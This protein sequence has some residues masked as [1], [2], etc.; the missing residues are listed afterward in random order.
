MLCEINIL[1]M[2]SEDRLYLLLWLET[3]PYSVRL[4]E[5]LDH[6]SS[7][8]IQSL[9]TISEALHKAGMVI[10]LHIDN[11][12]R[13]VSCI[14]RKYCSNNHLDGEQ[15]VCRRLCAKCIRTLYHWCNPPETCPT[16][17]VCRVDSFREGFRVSFLL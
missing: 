5:S 4:Q 7:C 2:L 8:P 3:S 11:L 1:L 15:V 13:I 6:E 17:T 14:D 16:A 9:A 10:S 12:P